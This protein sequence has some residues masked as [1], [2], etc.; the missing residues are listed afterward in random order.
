MTISQHFSDFWPYFHCVCTETVICA[1]PVK[2]HYSSLYR[3]DRA[4]FHFLLV[5]TIECIYKL[6]I[7]G[8]YKLSIKATSDTMPILS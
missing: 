4:T 7:L 1:L 6:I 3:V 2:I 5:T 8:T